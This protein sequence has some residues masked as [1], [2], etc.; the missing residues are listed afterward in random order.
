MGYGEGDTVSLTF[1]D[2]AKELTFSCTNRTLDTIFVFG[3]LVTFLITF[4]DIFESLHSKPP[5]ENYWPF[6]VGHLS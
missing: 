2:K 1:L 4:K 6:P 3:I 5:V